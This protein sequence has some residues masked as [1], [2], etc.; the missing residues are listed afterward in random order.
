M[1]DSL[2]RMDRARKAA[3]V[4]NYVTY[5]R[6]RQTQHKKHR[7]KVNAVKAS[8][9]ATVPRSHANRRPNVKREQILEER[10]YEIERDNRHLLK[11]I[12]DMH[13]VSVLEFALAFVTTEDASWICSSS[14]Y[15]LSLDLSI[16]WYAGTAPVPS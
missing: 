16:C 15:I 12:Y 1:P 10:Y 13:N 8:V 9:D 4:A 3:P 6:H 5:D 14:A 2:D 7:R 11:K